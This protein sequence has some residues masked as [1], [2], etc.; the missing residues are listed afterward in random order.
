MHICH[1]SI[2]FL[3]VWK[4]NGNV[5][6]LYVK[7]VVHVFN[8]SAA[9][10]MI[11]GNLYYDDVTE[12]FEQCNTFRKQTDDLVAKGASILRLSLSRVQTM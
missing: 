11:V 4:K 6:K 12:M 9:L 8:I 3:Y 10:I 5:E 2:Y 7:Y 1:I